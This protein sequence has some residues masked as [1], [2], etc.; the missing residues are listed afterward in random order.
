MLM[1]PKLS[2]M[3]LEVLPKFRSTMEKRSEREKFP[4]QKSAG[5][6]RSN[7][8]SVIAIII[9]SSVSLSTAW[10]RIIIFASRALSSFLSPSEPSFTFTTFREV[11]GDKAFRLITACCLFSGVENVLCVGVW[12]FYRYGISCFTSCSV[13]CLVPLKY[14]NCLLSEEIYCAAA[15]IFDICVRRME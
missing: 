11:E 2:R 5:W 7:R 4:E 13:S 12:L 3:V 1:G 14:H 10:H 9:R 6:N 8:V 15:G